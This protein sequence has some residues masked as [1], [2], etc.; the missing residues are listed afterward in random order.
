LHGGGVRVKSTVAS[1]TE[2]S[3]EIPS[4]FAHLPAEGLVHELDDALPRLTKIAY[5]KETEQW[6]KA[7]RPEQ[8]EASIVRPSD[9]PR[10]LV[11]DDNPHLREYLGDLLRP[12][13]DVTVARDGLEALEAIRARTP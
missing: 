4:G 5:P 12:H 6:R 3:V 7:D 1:G 10:I 13:Y 8:P 11:V 9:A 2:F